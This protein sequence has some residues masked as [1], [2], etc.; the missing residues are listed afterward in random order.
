MASSRWKRFAFFDR[1]NLSLPPAVVK[2]IIPSSSSSSSNNSKS[3]SSAKN[4][5]TSDNNLDPQILYYNDIIS[6]DVNHESIEDVV[7]VGCG[8]Y[9]SFVG[10]TNV[11]LPASL[12]SNNI[13]VGDDYHAGC[14]DGGDGIE[15]GAGGH[16][17]ND[18]NNDDDGMGVATRRGVGGDGASAMNAGLIAL[19]QQTPQKPNSNASSAQHHNV[20]TTTSSTNNINN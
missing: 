2:D 18:D 11:S 14:G 3:I 20:L 12:S 19:R 9:F 15:A 4:N 6:S 10:A 17:S 16:S 13:G 1:K 5:T 8:E 7:K